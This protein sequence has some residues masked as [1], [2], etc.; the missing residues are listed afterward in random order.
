M[1][2]NDSLCT[3]PMEQRKALAKAWLNEQIERDVLF[4]CAI[5]HNAINVERPIHCP[6]CSNLFCFDCITQ[7]FNTARPRAS[8]YLKNCPCCQAKVTTQQFT[9]CRVYQEVQEFIE[10]LQRNMPELIQ[11]MTKPV[12]FCDTHQKELLLFCQKCRK[13]IC[14]KCVL[15]TYHRL[16]IDEVLELDDAREKLK[17]AIS[18]QNSFLV[19]RLAALNRAEARIDSRENELHSEQ[20]ELLKDLK[21]AYD[22]LIENIQ[23]D[24]DERIR[25]YLAPA[26]A[27]TLQQR[28]NVEKI[29]QKKIELS[30][31]ETS[32]DVV[33]KTI[34][35]L[36]AITK[37]HS[38]SFPV[39]QFPDTKF[40]NP[41]SPPPLEFNFSIR[42]FSKKILEQTKPVI[43]MPERIDGFLLQLKGY[44]DAEEDVIKISLNILDGYDINDIKVICYPAEG[45]DPLVRRLDLKKSEDNTVLE[46]PDFASMNDFLNVGTDELY[47]RMKFTLWTTYYEKCRHM[48][49]CVKKLSGDKQEAIQ[50]IHKVC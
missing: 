19:N 12:H 30:S 29:I 8:L 7:W 17:A 25:Q 43:S 47:I 28:T 2:S 9:P 3:S 49:W 21:V 48:D 50:D 26:K 46:F 35:M 23:E 27:V 6:H 39:L 34:R 5:C 45:R 44:H 1:A 11:L 38:E 15:N 13:C 24:K 22:T 37:M 14:V 33:M 20:G 4:T 36:D 16:H 31:E 32:P 10:R 42:G 40:A 41:I 18:Q